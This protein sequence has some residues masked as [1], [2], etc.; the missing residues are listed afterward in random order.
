MVQ[1]YDAIVIGAGQ[2]GPS[3]AA[4]LAGEG[5]KVALIERNL[6]GGTCVNTG[7]TPTKAMV[8]SAY[9]A[10]LARRGTD[11]GVSI[12][13]TVSVDMREVKRRKDGI[14]GAARSG[15]NEWLSALDNLT[16]MRGHARFIG[17]HAVSVD[18]ETITAPRIFLNVG[19]R[20]VIPDYPGIGQISP[21]TNSAI[22]ELDTIPEHLVI[23]GGGY[24]GLEFAQMFSRF[25]SAVT[26]IE[27]GD[28]LLKR[29]DEDASQTV[30]EMLKAEGIALRLSADCISFEKGF[31]GP[32]VNVDCA[33][34][35]P[36]VEGSH[37]LLAIGRRPN[38]DDLGLGA[39]GIETDER[40]FIRTNDR[41]ETSVNG[42]WALG[43]CNGRGAFTHTAYND[44]EI[45]ADNLLA[46]ANRA[47][48]DR[49]PCYALYTD[50]PLGRA[51]MTETEARKGGRPILVGKRPMTRVARAKEKGETTGFMKVVVDARTEKILG[52]TIFGTGGDEAIHV[53]LG[54]IQSGASYKAVR[55]TVHIHPTVSELIPTILGE[56]KEI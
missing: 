53:L 2:A 24:I 26:I 29:E 55:D 10:N 23:V 6:V 37:V 45:V 40:G 39:A 15:L 22:L 12:S 56:L 46:G 31:S 47:V 28:R 49:Q 44:Y 17:P 52:A 30:T 27:R 51:G 32:V 14:V 38:T 1:A 42:I 3:L 34:G 16:L 21:L 4:R 35:A 41:L 7:C 19:G 50:P 13:G 20:A 5:H 25:G 36:K 54:A 48:S 18:G 43:D 11:Y 9:A 8:A 33:H